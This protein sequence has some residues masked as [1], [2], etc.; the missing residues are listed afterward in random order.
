MEMMARDVVCFGLNEGGS[1]LA[2]E[3]LRLSNCVD[4]ICK[5]LKRVVGQPGGRCP[6]NRGPH[7]ALKLE[8]S[9]VD[10]SCLLSLGHRQACLKAAGRRRCDSID[11]GLRQE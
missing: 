11:G 5:S 8:C 4:S 10:G 7:K 2:C 1:D 6:L 3:G 9:N